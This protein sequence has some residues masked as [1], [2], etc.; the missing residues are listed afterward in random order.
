MT[1]PSAGDITAFALSGNSRSGFL[2]NQAT[3]QVAIKNTDAS[4]II[5]KMEKIK[6]KIPSGMMK[7]RPSRTMI[8]L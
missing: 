5:P 6:V 8:L 7:G 2:K 4:Q 1:L 3:K